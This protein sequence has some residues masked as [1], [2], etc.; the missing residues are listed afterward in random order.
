MD[1]FLIIEYINI[2][3][4][5]RTSFSWF[6]RVLGGVGG[7]FKPSPYEAPIGAK[8]ENIMAD[9]N[10]DGRKRLIVM[11]DSKGAILDA[12]GSIEEA[13]EKTG[14]NKGAIM[15]CLNGTQSSVGRPARKFFWEVLAGD[16]RD[17]KR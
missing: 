6:L 9:F 13:S 3:L 12:F 11:S 10:K 15:R 2:L 14:I 1:L 17:S 8:K 5:R 16:F 7:G 4:F